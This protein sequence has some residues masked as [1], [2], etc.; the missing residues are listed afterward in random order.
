MAA[1]NASNIDIVRAGAKEGDSEAGIVLAAAIMTGAAELGRGF[2]LADE[3]ATDLEAGAA[4]VG[5]GAA[6]KVAAT[7]ALKVATTV[8]AVAVAGPTFK[9]AT[10]AASVGQL[11]LTRNEKKRKQMLKEAA[12][13]AALTSADKAEA[14]E[15][16]RRDEA[17]AEAAAARAARL[18]QLTDRWRALTGSWRARD[19]LFVGALVG[20]TLGAWLP[21][22]PWFRA[23]ADPIRAA[24]RK[25][26]EIAVATVLASRTVK[27]LSTFAQDLETAQANALVAATERADV[28]SKAARVAAKEAEEKTK[29]AR[30]L[31][32]GGDKKA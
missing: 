9:V 11:V 28:A 13:K 12:A 31:E 3:N 6:V 25:L 10:A 18:A 15:Q 4:A 22:S 5:A 8:A 2:G 16:A 23:N 29:K 27:A 7:A 21:A 30:S 14:A 20:A 26:A 19:K 32:E 1:K 24:V 17:R